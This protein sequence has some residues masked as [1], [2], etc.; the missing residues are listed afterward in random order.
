MQPRN[1]MQPRCHALVTIVLLC[2]ER[3]SSCM[4]EGLSH[5]SGMHK[6]RSTSFREQGLK[7]VLALFLAGIPCLYCFAFEMT[8]FSFIGKKRN[9]QP[10]VYISTSCSTRSVFDLQ[11][12]SVNAVLA[13]TIDPT[14]E[15]DLKRS[16]FLLS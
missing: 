9:A 15:L 6:E 12:K 2:K 14:E 3:P 1:L 8:D 10:H 11:P 16:S 4:A 5:G 13:K 7:Q